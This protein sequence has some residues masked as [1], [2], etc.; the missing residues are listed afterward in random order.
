M[1][2][3]HGPA[4]WAE[5][6]SELS[7]EGRNL[8]SIADKNAVGG[9][10]AVWPVVTGVE[11]K[12]KTEGNQ[13]QASFAR[14]YAVEVEAELLKFR[15]GI[16]ALMEKFVVQRQE[17]MIQKMRKTVEAP[18]VQHVDEIIE[19]P[20]GVQHRV[21]TIQAAQTTEEVSQVQFPDRAA[22][23]PCLDA[24]T[25]AARSSGTHR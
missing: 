17:Q 24:K 8:L 22:G 23:V 2:A 16:L 18:Q 9:R 21:P 15:D 3:E 4:D 11:Q 7:V 14:E 20:V 13:G 1:V 25:G 5:Q 6:P 10:R 19:V 12:E